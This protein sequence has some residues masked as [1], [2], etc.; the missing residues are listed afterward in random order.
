MQ[1][2]YDNDNIESYNHNEYPLATIQRGR[3]TSIKFEQF[4]ECR[5]CNILVI[6]WALVLCL[7]Y[8]YA[9][10]LGCCMPSCIYIRQSTLACVITYTCITN[11]Y[12]PLQLV[13]PYLGTCIFHLRSL[14][15]ACK[16][17]HILLF[18]HWV[19]F[20]HRFT[21]NTLKKYYIST[22]GT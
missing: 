4:V 7:I 2:R 15:Q 8:T 11:L 13:Y 12:I 20:L 6:T 10:A 9:L 5:K 22:Q 19:E 17:G 3:D 18:D 14:L 16:V 1:E 21:N